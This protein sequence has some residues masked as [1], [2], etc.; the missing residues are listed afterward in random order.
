MTLTADAETCINPKKKNLWYFLKRTTYLVET[1]VTFKPNEL[2]D[3][4]QKKPLS[5]CTNFFWLTPNSNLDYM[6]SGGRHNQ[7]RM[8]K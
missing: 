3:R 8:A 1:K 7:E 2:E 5:H 6:S 4:L